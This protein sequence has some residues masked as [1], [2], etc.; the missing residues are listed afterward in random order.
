MTMR[1]PFDMNTFDIDSVISKLDSGS[2][3]VVN[4][5][6]FTVS[7]AGNKTFTLT[8]AEGVETSKFTVQEL[9]VESF[10]E[11]STALGDGSLKADIEFYEKTGYSSSDRN[12]RFSN[13][14]LESG[15]EIL[16]VDTMFIN[17]EAPV[18]KEVYVKITNKDEYNKDFKISL[19]CAK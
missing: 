2:R 19:R 3:F 1:F 6:T 4:S 16:K 15:K 8:S 13:L 18:K 9:I 10:Q 17:L 7:S 12:V 14:N 5:T 11:G